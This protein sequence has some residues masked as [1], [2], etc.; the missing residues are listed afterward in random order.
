MTDSNSEFAKKMWLMFVSLV[1]GI[2]LEVFVTRSFDDFL[3]GNSFKVCLLYSIFVLTYI[4]SLAVLN[5]KDFLKNREAL[6][7]GG[8]IVVLLV[9]LLVFSK[10]KVDKGYFNSMNN[11][12]R[13]L[14]IFIVVPAAT[15]L[16]LN[17]MTY[18]A[19]ENHISRFG[20]TYLTSCFVNTVRYMGKP[21]AVLNDISK[22]KKQVTVRV[23][24]GTAVG[25]PLFSLLLFLLSRADSEMSKFFSKLFESIGDEWTA[26]LCVIAIGFFATYSS[27]YSVT[28][29][30]EIQPAES[31]VVVTRFNT[32][33]TAIVVIFMLL[34]YATFGIFRFGY[35]MG[36]SGLPAGMTYADYA[37]K[38]FSELNIVSIIN[39]TVFIL[40][41]S[42]CKDKTGKH[43]SIMKALLGSLIAVS[44]FLAVGALF[45]LLLYIG[46]YG[47]TQ[48]RIFAL[49]F[50]ISI[51]IIFAFSA[52]KLFKEKSRAAY[53]CTVVLMLW[54]IALNYVSLLPTA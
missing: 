1:V 39:M 29:K 9:S 38:G 28:I 35:F 19:K 43:P 44:V 22:G 53:Y 46:A 30:K 15:M 14:N 13:M 20:R 32:T 6:G 12:L 2:A 18:G 7:S 10:T 45:R 27:I 24:I 21:F 34:A 25:M 54:Y 47:L 37:I 51:C 48:R 17:F 16:T 50:E 33:S 31:E 36:F 41:C 23:L 5:F 11:I 8:F 42:F 52:F 26:R 49:W 3:P 4:V 40:C